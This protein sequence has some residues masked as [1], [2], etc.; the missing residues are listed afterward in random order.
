MAYEGHEHRP[1]VI[2]GSITAF[3]SAIRGNERQQA[4]PV[5]ER[6]P[7]E[8]T[9]QDFT[10]HFLAGPLFGH[11]LLLVNFLIWS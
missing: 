10:P 4:S 2:K 1:D 11:W 5:L 7:N 6:L 8:M 3:A 9:A